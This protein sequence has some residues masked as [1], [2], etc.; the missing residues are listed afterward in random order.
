MKKITALL[1][2]ILSLI[3]SFSA[4]AYLQ[5]D[6]GLTQVSFTVSGVSAEDVSVTNLGDS[7]YTYAGC[8]TAEEGAHVVK[9]IFHTVGKYYFRITK[10]EQIIVN[11]NA[12]YVSA[13]REDKGYTLIVKVDLSNGTIPMQ[14]PEKEE[15]AKSESAMGWVQVGPDWVYKNPDG[16]VVTNQWIKYNSAWY[17]VGNQGFMLR[18]QWIDGV[19]YVNQDGVRLTNT[20]TP[21][22][23]YVG[24]DGKWQDPQKAD[25]GT[26]DNT[27][28][29]THDVVYVGGS[30]TGTWTIHYNNKYTNSATGAVYVIDKVEYVEPKTMYIYYHLESGYGDLSIGVTGYYTEETTLAEEGQRKNYGTNLKFT[31]NGKKAKL[32][33]WARNAEIYLNQGK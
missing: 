5:D 13:S 18:N 28:S 30:T 23:Y 17:Y 22:G 33:P 32:Y 8:E 2:V 15:S 27:K 14:Q 3:L 7:R 16:S 19:Y 11:G 24:A 26:R 12:K 10:H 1:A 20:T 21:D 29:F 25:D 9:L 6:V 4:Q 31:E